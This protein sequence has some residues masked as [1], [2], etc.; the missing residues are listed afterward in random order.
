MED[1]AVRENVNSTSKNKKYF[2]S[3][4]HAFLAVMDLAVLLLKLPKI[5]NSQKA[6]LYIHPSFIKNATQNPTE[7]FYKGI[8]PKNNH[9]YFSYD[10]YIYLKKIEGIKVYNIGIVVKLISKLKVHKKLSL[11]ND[12]N[13]WYPI[14][15]FI[16]KR[17][18][19]NTVYIPV[20][21]NGVGLS[22]VFNKY[23]ENFKLVEVQHGSVLNYP[24]YSL[25]SDLP[26]VNAFYYRTEKDKYFLEDNLFA[27]QT[28]ELLQIPQ[29]EIT[30]LSKTNRIEILYVSSYEF[31]DLHPVFKNFINNVPQNVFIRVRLHPR[32]SNLEAVFSKHLEKNN[33]NFEIHKY[34]NWYENLPSNSIVISP[35]SS[36]IEEAVNVGL[37][38]IIIDPLGGKRFNYLL[39]GEN[40]VFSDNLS[41]LNLT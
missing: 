15:N 28:V 1:Y 29:E 35:F 6:I 22:L 3:L 19:N 24:P 9:I 10:K 39:N 38:V 18:N 40:C 17:L 36:V 34:S 30:F 7:N 27:R 20:Y 14:Q 8:K 13:I 31:N 21:S 26:L 2:K 25:V 23:R 16:C 32:Q 12:F 41:D 4:Y 5:K 37:K 33:V 11:Q